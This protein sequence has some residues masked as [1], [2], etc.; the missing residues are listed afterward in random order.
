MEEM[1]CL[2]RKKLRNTSSNCSSESS[3]FHFQERSIMFTQLPKLVLIALLGAAAPIAF[4][5]HTATGPHGG[6][7]SGTV[8]RKGSTVTGSGTATG[9]RGKSV[10]SSGSA[11]KTAKGATASGTVTGPKGGTSTASGS[12]TSNPNGSKTVTGTATGP[13]GKSKSGTGTVPPQQ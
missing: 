3:K 12:S 7:A 4:A 10:T 13:R 6:T 8:T 11:T 2:N 5:Q 9:A 1:R